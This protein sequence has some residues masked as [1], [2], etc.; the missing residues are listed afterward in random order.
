MLTECKINMNFLYIF[1]KELVENL[2]Q[3]L[4]PTSYEK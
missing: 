1:G 4:K 2:N 3:P